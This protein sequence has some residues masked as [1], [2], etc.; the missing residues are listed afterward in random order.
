ME[1]WY[2]SDS[3]HCFETESWWNGNARGSVVTHPEL[4]VL[5]WFVIPFLKALLN[6][7]P[8]TFVKSFL[9]SWPS[10]SNWAKLVIAKFSWPRLLWQGPQWG[11][12][13]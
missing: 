12:A 5:M 2:G 3:F 11:T 9:A 8:E 1:W 13:D 6:I 4:S 7:A 10:F